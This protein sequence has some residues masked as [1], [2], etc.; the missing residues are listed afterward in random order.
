MVT[1]S[2][3]VA[4]CNLAATQNEIFSGSVIL[5]T[6]MGEYVELDDSQFSLS[7]NTT[8]SFAVNTSDWKPEAGELTLTLLIVDSYGRQIQSTSKDVVARSNGWNIGISELSANGDIRISI[9][10]DSYQRLVGITCLLTV[11]SPGSSWE[12]ET[13]LIDIG[14][15][16]YAPIIKIDDPGVLSKDDLIKAELRCNIPY[17]IDDNPED[18]TAQAF[19]Q[20][21]DTSALQDSDLVFGILTAVAVLSLAYFV[22]L[23]NNKNTSKPKPTKLQTNEQTTTDQ[24]TKEVVEVTEIISEIDDFSLELEEHTDDS[25]PIDIDEAPPADPVI[26]AQD[27]HTASGRLASIRD[28]MSSDEKPKDTRPLG[29]RMADFFND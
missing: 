1:L 13:Q 18:D 19:F 27:D 9:A 29:D 6:S 22:G 5:I 3:T 4:S 15:I 14:G 7:A 11:E 26:I 25:A 24:D 23:L 16:D 2:T 20:P 8:E 10:R 21:A 12:G 28:E 17:D